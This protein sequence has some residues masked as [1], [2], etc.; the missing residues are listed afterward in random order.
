MSDLKCRPTNSTKR[1][2]AFVLGATVACMAVANL[3]AAQVTICTQSGAPVSADNTGASGA[4]AAIQT[5]LNSGDLSSGVWEIPSGVYLIDAGLDVNRT[6][7][8]RTV[9]TAGTAVCPYNDTGTTCAMLMAAPNLTQNSPAGHPML[10]IDASGFV[11]DHLIV[12]GNRSARL[13]GVTCQGDG[14]NYHNSN[15]YFRLY[16]TSSVFTNNV[17][18]NAVC[19]SGMVVDA[20]SM[21]IQSNYFYHNGDHETG[22]W[23]DGLTVTNCSGCLITNNNLTDNTDVQLVMGNGTNTIIS[24]N[25]F[26]QF[27]QSS[28]AGFALDNFNN[29]A[30][31]NFAGTVVSANNI[32]CGSDGSRCDIAVN[33]GPYA[34]YMSGGNIKGGAFTGNTVSGGRVGVLVQGAG[35]AAEPTSVYGNTVTRGS[36]VPDNGQTVTMKCPDTRTLHTGNWVYNDKNFGHQ[37]DSYLNTNGENGAYYPGDFGESWYGCH[38]H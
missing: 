4:A 10:Q 22:L 19:G 29:A 27:T 23:A 16:A 1:I 13:S 26:Q 7:T 25:T 21:T 30:L 24:S 6:M 31:G 8:W 32:S 37:G 9:G 36:G 3:A 18:R 15:I 2:R 34:W 5:C 35:T 12:E 38:D 33:V 14:E 17:T 28:F 20:D 11:M